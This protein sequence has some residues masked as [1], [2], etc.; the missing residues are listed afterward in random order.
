[1]KRFL[2]LFLLLTCYA[3]TE[4]CKVCTV[5]EYSNRLS[6]L[7]NRDSEFVYSYTPSVQEYCGDNL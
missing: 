2:Y 6:Q 5:D 4:E 3:C 7:E 1:M